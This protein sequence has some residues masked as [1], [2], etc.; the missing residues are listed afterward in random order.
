MK[1]EIFEGPHNEWSWR[2]VGFKNKVFCR[3]GETF[4]SKKRAK[5]SY[6]FFEKKLRT[7]LIE[8]SIIE[9]GASR[10]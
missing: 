2:V 8:M 3:S 5:S 6:A 4:V 1:I 10:Q 7:S 9:N